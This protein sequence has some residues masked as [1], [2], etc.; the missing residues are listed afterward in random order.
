MNSTG[1]ERAPVVIPSSLLI[2]KSTCLGILII[3]NITFNS[4]T[5]VVLRRMRELSPTTKVFLTSMTVLDIITLG[6][7]IPVFVCTLINRWPFGDTLCIVYGYF[8]VSTTLLYYIHLP[9]VNLD[10]FIAISRPYRYPT[11]VTVP[12]ARA[13]VV[14][15]WC[16]SPVLPVG[17]LNA[18]DIRYHDTVH[19]C[20]AQMQEEDGIVMMFMTLLPIVLAVV[21][22]L[23]L[24]LVARGHAAAIDVQER[25]AGNN[26]RTHSLERK[27]FTTFFIMTAC[28]TVCMI[29]QVIVFSIESVKTGGPSN[30]WSICFSQILTFSNT[31]VNVIVYYLRTT[32][33]RKAI[34]ALIW[35]R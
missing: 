26:N 10:R 15:L 6:H 16:L 24:F 22:F 17:L 32:T 28:V 2:L 30:Y 19:M 35:A 21:L 31:I 27:T 7:M 11:L 4:V 1:I 3:L 8:G 5:L 29:P 14:C 12:R 23:R 18:A 34:H 13:M 33:F 9:L 20:F 25:V